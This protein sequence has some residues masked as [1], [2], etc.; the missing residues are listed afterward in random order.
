[1]DRE[2]QLFDFSNSVFRSRSSEFDVKLINN[3]SVEENDAI[4]Q[5]ASAGIRKPKNENRNGK[6]KSPN[7][8]ILFDIV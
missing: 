6:M 2:N 3:S 8:V 7:P 4:I 1:M 5:M